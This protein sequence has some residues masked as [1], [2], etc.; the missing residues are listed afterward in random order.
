MAH[1]RSLCKRGTRGTQEQSVLT[2]G[3]WLE[4][5]GV[6]INRCDRENLPKRLRSVDYKESLPTRAGF[7]ANQVA[8]RGGASYSL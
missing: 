6:R 3:A 7:R 4:K 2:T 1:T 8:L 5:S